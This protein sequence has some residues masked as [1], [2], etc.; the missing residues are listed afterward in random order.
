MREIRSPASLV[1]KK[2]KWSMEREGGFGL[3]S[4]KYP[5]VLA[6]SSV[7]STCVLRKTVQEAAASDRN[8]VLC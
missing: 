1:R 7:Q 6:V 4:L 8:T 3:C 2:M 5:F